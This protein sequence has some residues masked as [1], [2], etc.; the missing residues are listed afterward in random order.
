MPIYFDSGTG[1]GIGVEVRVTDGKGNSLLEEIIP[2]SLINT[3]GNFKVPKEGATNN[4]GELLACYTALK[5]ALKKEKTLIYGDS[6]LVLDYWSQGKYNKK[7]LKNLDTIKL[8]GEVKK[9]R[10][11][12]EKKGGKILKISGDYNPADLGFHK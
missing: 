1:R 12:F 3:H 5:I 7:N 9:L 11:E 4:F 8:I 6:S 2:T 10:E